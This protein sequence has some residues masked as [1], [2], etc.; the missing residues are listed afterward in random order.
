MRH[1]LMNQVIQ[2]EDMLELISETKAE[3]GT[4]VTWDP[5]SENLDGDITI[6]A[7]EVTEDKTVWKVVDNK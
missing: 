5:Q 1:Y 3:I 2:N 4:K 7:I 6:Q